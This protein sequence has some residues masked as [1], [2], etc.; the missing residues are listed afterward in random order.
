[1]AIIG[2]RQEINFKEFGQTVQVPNNPT[3]RLMYYFKCV[4]DTIEPDEDALIYFGNYND[5]QSLDTLKKKLL[6]ALCVA[7][8]PDKLIEVGIFHPVE[9]LEGGSSNTFFEISHSQTTIA[10]GEG[11]VIGG[12]RVRAMKIMMLTQSWLQTY[13]LNPLGQLVAELERPAISHTTSTSSQP[14]R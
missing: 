4:L 2:Q 7:F 1:M 6:L 14:R 11:I 10:A 5:Y 8:S 3:A 9:S 13:Y 12:H